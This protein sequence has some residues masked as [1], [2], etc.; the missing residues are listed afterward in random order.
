MRSDHLPI[1]IY[2][3]VEIRTV[4]TL[5]IFVLLIGTLSLKVRN[6]NEIV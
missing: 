6:K 5:N 4:F 2:A 3:R 1:F